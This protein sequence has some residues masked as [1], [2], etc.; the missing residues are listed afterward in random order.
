[1]KIIPSKKEQLLNPKTGEVVT[2]IAIIPEQKDKDF[3][4]MFKLMSTKVIQD[5]K[6]GGINGATD[7]LFWFIDQIQEMEPNQDP[8]VLADPQ[9]I[10]DDLG[11]G[12]RT[13][14][15]HLKLLME[16]G[17]IEQIKKRHHVYRV[18]PTMLFKGTLSKY[19]G[20]DSK[21]TKMGDEKSE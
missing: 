2:A 6:A 15:R 21:S 20:G 18:N 9:T 1:M 7:T 11:T 10:A 13:V 17:Y 8:V 12:E 5:L 4:K 14:Y 3:V 19:F 16:Y